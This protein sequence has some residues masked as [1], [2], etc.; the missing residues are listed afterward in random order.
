MV[1]ELAVVRRFLRAASLRYM[2][3]VTS[4]EQC[5]DLKTLTMEDLVGRYKSYD[6]RVR[7]SYGDMNEGEHLLLTRGCD[8][9]DDAS[10]DSDDNER[11]LNKKKGKFYNC[12]IR[13]H[14]AKECSKLRKEMA[15]LAT[16]DD[17]PCL[18]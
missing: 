15:L 3:V 9:D 2:N 6:E 16:A 5:V 13:G 17:K 18:L 10:I 1:D 12:G 14:L 11:K 8:R 4:I 7:F